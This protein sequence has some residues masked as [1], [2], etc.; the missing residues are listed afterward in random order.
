M[1]AYV[2]YHRDT[3]RLARRA[4]G[5]EYFASEAAAKRH[6]TRYLN[7]QDYLISEAVNFHDNI[8]Q[9]VARVN[10]RTGQTYMEPVNTPNYMSPAS[11]AYWQM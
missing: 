2:I 10:I 1:A 8:E 3:T 11:E 9:V 4:N 7:D 5:D 6:R